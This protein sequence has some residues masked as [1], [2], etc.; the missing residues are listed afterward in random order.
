MSRS[1][2]LIEDDPGVRQTLV[3]ILEHRGYEVAAVGSVADA[4]DAG[5]HGLALV[6]IKLPDGSGV[7]V[8][9]DLRAAQ[10]DLDVVFLTAAASLETAIDAV[11]LGAV[12]YLQKPCPPATLLQVIGEIFD[13]RAM[14]RALTEAEKQSAVGRLAAGVAH[15]IGTPLNIISGR[16]EVLLA[17]AEPGSRDAEGLSIILDQIDR[18][19]AL[20]RQM[21]D[22]SRA[23]TGERTRIFMSAVLAET[24][25]LLSTRTMKRQVRIDNRVADADCAVIGS[26][27]QLQQ[28]LLN[29]VLNAA[30][31]GANTVVVECAPAG[32]AT[33]ELR[34][35]DDGPGIDAAKL[36]QVFEPFYTTKPRGQGTGLGL[37]V[38]Q[39]IVSDHG[40][41]IHA[42]RAPAGGARFV[43]R[44]P[45]A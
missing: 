9:K 2:I 39:G 11:E 5:G 23:D 13:K 21:L 12:R 44:L 3:D 20:V 30:D 14:R 43:V 6:D 31:A 10:P 8:A 40:G 15:E 32:D 36:E 18:I 42:E 34:V 22:F 28:L 16:A 26:L 45:L 41:T 7:D 35:T 37:A 29:L 25:P 19:A 1:I 17:R 27:H 24:L 38:V 33:L 4:P